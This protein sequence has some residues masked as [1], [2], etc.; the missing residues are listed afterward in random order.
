[1]DSDSY[2]L[3]VCRYVDLNPVRADMVK[4]PQA[5]AWSSYRAHTG[6]AP[7]PHWLDSKPLYAQLAP[8]GYHAIAANKYAEFVAQGAGVN[9]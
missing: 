2:L 5:Y 9:L 6:Q 4:H 8:K 3:E 1:M 7:H